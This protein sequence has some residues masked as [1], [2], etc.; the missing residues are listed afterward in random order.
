MSA[1][2]PAFIDLTEC[3]VLV[4]GGGAVAARK[5]AGLLDAGARVTV[6][7]PEAS[8]RLRKQAR[9]KRIAL[10]LREFRPADLDGAWMVIAATD[11]RA[12]NRRI[13]DEARRR[14][15]LCNVVDDPALCTFQAPS[16]ARRGKLQIAVSTGG[17]SPSLARDIR[18]KLQRHYGVAYETFVDGLYDLRRHLQARYPR[19]PE[20]RREV[21]ESFLRSDAPAALLKG[22]EPKAFLSE[23]E[24]WKS[25]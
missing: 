10:R 25:L 3:A 20:R 1:L 12:V 7:A 22:G 16:V 2:Y 18:R 9:E 8:L 4:V 17:A 6:V 15:I 23:V 5:V 19:Q 11:A 13:A 21:A 14:R 24:R